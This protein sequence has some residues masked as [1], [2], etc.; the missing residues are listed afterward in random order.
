METNNNILKQIKI[1]SQPKVDQ[2]YFDQ[3]KDKMLREVAQQPKAKVFYLKPIFW[4]S[5]AAAS[6]LILFGIQ[7]FNTEQEPQVS[8]SSLSKEELSAYVEEHIDEYEESTL[9]DFNQE[10]QRA[11][12][13]EKINPKEE[14]PV[15]NVEV[16]TQKDFIGS[17]QL[18]QEISNEDLYL[19]LMSDE[20]DL[21]ELD[22]L[23]F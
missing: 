13:K 10:K 11:V 20:F 16:S 9:G 17:K 21:D 18:L 1:K 6:L 19:Y 14:N 4:L 15:S 3:L 22:D 8:L 2:A 7:F 12:F 5:T 23:Q